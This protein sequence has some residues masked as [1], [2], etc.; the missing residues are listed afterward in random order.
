MSHKPEELTDDGFDSF[1]MNAQLPVL[2][3]LWAP[4]CVPC[5]AMAPIIDK[6]SK[7]SDGKLLVAKIDVEK[8]PNIMNRYGVRGI[9][10]LLL[11]REG[12]EAARQVG[13]LS[14]GQ[15][16]IWLAEHQVD[17]A[18]QVPMQ[19]AKALDCASF[20]GDEGL[21][22]F[23]AQR[24]IRHAEAGDITIGLDSFWLGGK[25]TTSAAMVH[26]PDSIAFERITGLPIALARLLDRCGYLSAEQ[27]G[28]L[29]TA[30]RAGK[31]YRLVPQRFMYWWLGSESAPWTDY[32]RDPQLVHL[33]SR[34]QVLCAAQLAGRETEPEGWSA[35]GEQAVSLLQGYQQ[36]DRQLERIFA[37]L[38]RD[39]SPSPIST[40]SDKWSH[41]ALN[42]N[43]AQ[44]QQLEIL[45]GW[46]DEDRATPDIRLDWFKDKERQ[47]PAGKLTQEEI[48]LLREEWLARNP[49][50]IAK[51][52]A[53]HHNLPQLALPVSARMQQTLNQLLAEAPDF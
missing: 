29:F 49:E 1:L 52:N 39:L 23:I 14:S 24:T 51:E 32:L 27:V 15:L 16:N 38:L 43:W 6:M 35:I 8:Y 12:A 44:F 7:N 19:Q 5:H 31:D 36:P 21:H 40:D 53:F 33:L 22:D 26:Q 13:A 9:P 11:F 46:S 20:Y 30:L 18:S 48:T 4:W 42:M 41:I 37:V 2:V 28:T 45:S 3:D 34:W 25:G 47:S 10:T 50:F 17:I